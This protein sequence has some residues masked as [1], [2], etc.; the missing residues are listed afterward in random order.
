[1]VFVCSIFTT[2]SPEH[3]TVDCISYIFRF[4]MFFDKSHLSFP[5]AS[6]IFSWHYKHIPLVCSRSLSVSPTRCANTRTIRYSVLFAFTCARAL[7]TFPVSTTVSVF[8]TSPHCVFLC[9]HPICSGCKCLVG[10]Y[11][12]ARS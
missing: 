2:F 9:S 6:F 12:L 5:Y 4:T 8:M 3:F 11:L 10:C 7:A 1:M